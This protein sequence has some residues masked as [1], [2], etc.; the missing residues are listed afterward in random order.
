[1]NIQ[2]SFFDGRSLFSFNYQLLCCLVV[3]WF[4]PTCNLYFGSIIVGAYYTVWKLKWN[5]F[6]TVT[7]TFTKNVLVMY[8]IHYNLC[9]IETANR[10]VIDDYWKSRWP[11]CHS[12][13]N[14][15]SRTWDSSPGPSVLYASAQPLNHWACIRRC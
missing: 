11:F 6:V 14:P 7:K 3:F 4:N 5:M 10:S 2:S 13:V 15:R 9:F 8:W 1:M 12:I